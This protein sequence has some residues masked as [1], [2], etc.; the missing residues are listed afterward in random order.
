LQTASKK[1]RGVKRD[2]MED[3]LLNL[4]NAGAPTGVNIGDVEMAVSLVAG[5]RPPLKMAAPQVG[6]EYPALV[7]RRSYR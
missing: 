2:L 4:T 1:I 7:G 6:G 3:M 5:D